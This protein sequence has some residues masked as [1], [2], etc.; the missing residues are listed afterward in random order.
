MIS[1]ILVCISSTHAQIDYPILTEFVADN[2]QI[3]SESQVL[4]LRQKLKVYETETTHQI[5]IL[6][7]NDL[8]GETIETYALEVFNRNKMG[9]E[10]KDN[11]LL[12]LFSKNDRKVRLE[13]G[14]GF[15]SIITDAI[16]S[17]IIRDIMIPEFKQEHYFNGIDLATSKIIEIIND[18]VYANEFAKEEAKDND[19]PLLVKIILIVFVTAFLGVFIFIGFKIFINNYKLLINLYKGL[20]IGKI[21]VYSFP[22]MFIMAAIAILVSSLFLVIPTVILS[23]FLVFFI[24]MFSFD[25]KI[26][27]F[28]DFSFN[29]DNLSQTNL[30]I[31]LVVFLVIIPLIMALIKKTYSGVEPFKFSLK[32]D[33]KY[34]SKHITSFGSNSSS[35]SSWSSSSSSSFSG[36][37]GSS[38]GGGASGSW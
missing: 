3:F 10:K 38:G 20:I 14:Y 7:I 2:A 1:F 5:V 18:P 21:S 37:G 19:I 24:S 29:Q 36:G 9:Q 35:L 23:L 15:E 31:F 13:V 32:N 25:L 11:G 27:P 16:S 30:I 34:I 28:L 6:T 12:L 4:K 33:K 8:E 26:E 17:R 22:F